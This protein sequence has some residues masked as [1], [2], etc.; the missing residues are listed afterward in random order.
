MI[1]LDLNHFGFQRAGR[2]ERRKEKRR[3]RKGRE[4]KSQTRANLNGDELDCEDTS[5]IPRVVI[6][7]GGSMAA[8]GSKSMSSVHQR[9]GA[10]SQG[11]PK[12]W[13]AGRGADPPCKRAVRCVMCE[14]VKT[15]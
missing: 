12:W 8:S 15:T 9:R 3:R 2:P 1:T 11:Q 6:S 4:E 7:G 13:R 5:G 10:P 14:I